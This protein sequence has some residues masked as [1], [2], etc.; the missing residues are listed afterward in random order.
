VL[1]SFRYLTAHALACGEHS[2]I[3]RCLNLQESFELAV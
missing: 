3:L 1:F 2:I